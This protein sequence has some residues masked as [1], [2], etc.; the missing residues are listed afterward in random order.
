MSSGVML[1]SRTRWRRPAFQTNLRRARAVHHDR[2][3]IAQDAGV[4]RRRRPCGRARDV[5]GRRIERFVVGSDH[6]QRTVQARRELTVVVQVRVVDEGAGTRRREPHDEAAFRL[7]HRRQTADRRRSTRARRRSSCRAPS[8]ASEWPSAP[9]D[10]SRRDLDRLVRGGAQA[11]DRAHET[12]VWL[13]GASRPLSDEP[14]RR[15]TSPTDRGSPI[16]SVSLRACR[17]ASARGARRRAPSPGL[18]DGDAEDHAC[19]ARAGS[20]CRAD[21][22]RHSRAGVSSVDGQPALRRHV[23]HDVAVE[24]PVPFALRRPRH[25]HRP[26]RWQQLRHD[27]RAGRR[28]RRLDRAAPS[29]RLSTV[30]VEAVQV[31]RV[32]L[33][34]EIDDA[35]AHGLAERDRSAA[36]WPATKPVDHERESRLQRRRRPR[37]GSSARDDLAE[38]LRRQAGP[39]GDDEDAIRCA[40]PPAGSTTNAPASSRNGTGAPIVVAQ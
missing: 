40:A 26:A 24:E 12:C 5:V 4:C 10:D 29:P 15:L 37:V 34:A 33:R 14:A 25:R 13:G 9:P 35:P 2:F 19:H 38:L 17:A 32:G 39:L 6:D 11:A 16:V 1:I 31:H 27:R 36:R 3:R 7:D 23:M 30:E 21:R 20:C 28:P 22:V 8:R 18:D